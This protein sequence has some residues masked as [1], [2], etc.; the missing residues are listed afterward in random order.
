MK[1]LHCSETFRKCTQ[2]HGVTSCK[3]WLLNSAAVGNSNLTCSCCTLYLIL[4]VTGTCLI[5][6]SYW[7]NQFLSSFLSATLEVHVGVL[8]LADRLSGLLLGVRLICVCLDRLMSYSCAVWNR[9]IEGMHGRGRRWRICTC[10][11]VRWRWRE[12]EWQVFLCGR[13]L[14]FK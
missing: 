7:R 11:R 2:V 12:K 13:P 1:A 10:K 3:R 5:F 6:I 8:L 9:K 4:L 14:Q